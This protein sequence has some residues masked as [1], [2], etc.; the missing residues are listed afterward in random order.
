[1][2]IPAPQ[3]FLLRNQAPEVA[4]RTLIARTAGE[5]QQP[6]RRDPPL[7]FSDPLSHQLSHLIEIPGTLLLLRH[8]PAGLS[9]LDS[10]LDRLVH[11]AAQIGGPTIRTDIPSVAL[12]SVVTG[13]RRMPFGRPVV[14]EV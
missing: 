5:R 12:C 7:G 4:R 8:F 6:L 1:M 13:C 9:A 2:M 14:P 3:R 10:T 11:G